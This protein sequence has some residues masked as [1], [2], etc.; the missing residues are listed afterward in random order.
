M[1]ILSITYLT[2]DSF[3][4]D[5]YHDHDSPRQRISSP[6]FVDVEIPHTDDDA[7]SREPTPPSVPI[8]SKQDWNS[9]EYYRL[10]YTCPCQ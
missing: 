10:Y 7:S 3:N 2:S 1:F 8:L 9:R 4:D 5:D 6:D